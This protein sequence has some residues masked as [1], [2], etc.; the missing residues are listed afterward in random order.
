VSSTAPAPLLSNAPTNTTSRLRVKPVLLLLCTLVAFLVSDPWFAVLEDEAN[1][2]TLAREPAG[3]TIAAFINGTGQHE[4]P[5]V[6]D[7]LLHLWLPIGGAAPW[8]IRLPSVVFYLAGLLLFAAV[9]RKLAGDSAYMPLLWLGCLWPFGFHFGRLIGWYSW[10]FFLVGLITLCYLRYLEEPGWRNWTALVVP[11]LLLVYSN[12]YG[13]IILGCLGFDMLRRTPTRETVRVL[14]L[15]FAVLVTAYTPML[16]AAVHVA[17]RDV[18][19][20]YHRGIVAAYHLYTWF[21]SEAV[22]PWFWA[23]SIPASIAIGVCGV[24]LV[25]LL[26]RKHLYFLVYGIVL[27]GGL[28]AVGAVTTKRMLFI[29]GWILVP[30][31]IA[32]TV[33]R[34]PHLRRA[35][36][37]S[38]AFIAAVGWYGILDRTLYAST[39]FVEPWSS[40]ADT[41]AA[42]L[43]TGGLVVTNSPSFRF[44]AQYS[45]Q[46]AGIVPASSLPGAVQHDRIQNVEDWSPSRAWGENNVLFITG[47]NT[48]VLHLTKSSEE[49]LLSHCTLVSTA[50]MVPDSGHAFKASMFKGKIP[51]RVSL[52]RFNCS[53]AL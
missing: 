41:A 23:L 10:C 4:H 8:A 48:S 36:I 26:P 17:R 13:W 6:S 21:V 37:G 45:L 49:A 39:H 30:L 9:A 46:R 53:G 20:F 43:Q 31:A 28:A 44:Y 27:F 3:K 15:T 19:S 12:Y 52:Q 51:Y 5:P 14:A 35:L 38:L 7:L 16:A 32:T 42:T 25:M 34:R 29:S 11:S 22:A 50:R 33:Q 24:T 40:V 47:V 2:V 18:P 1:I